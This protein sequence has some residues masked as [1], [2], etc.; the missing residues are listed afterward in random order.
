MATLITRS[1]LAD[2]LRCRNKFYYKHIRELEVGAPSKPMAEGTFGHIGLAAGYRAFKTLQQS[3]PGAIDQSLLND[4]NLL[5]TFKTAALHA[6]DEA[7]ARG[8]A[9][10]RGKEE[11]LGLNRDQDEETIQTIKDAVCYYADAMAVKDYRRYKFLEIERPYDYTVREID[12]SGVMDLVAV[13]TEHTRKKVVT[14]FDHKFPGNVK[15]ALDYLRIDVQMLFYE[16]VVWNSLVK[17]GPYDDVELQ[18][19]CIRREVPPGYGARPLRTA[20]GTLSKASRD[21]M[22]YLRRETL[23]HSDRQRANVQAYFERVAQEV[24]EKKAESKP[25]PLTVI[26]T[27]GESCAHSCA[28]F[29]RCGV[30]LL[31]GAPTIGNLV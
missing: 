14:V 29:T 30:D 5:Y 4:V 11:P 13:D 17:N 31:G 1:D 9:E 28:Y 12:F 8:T 10:Y 25:L 23:V 20:N 26:K 19:N 7:I 3:G 16:V 15:D 21:P 22:D 2:Y 24:L 18:F 27:G 6:M